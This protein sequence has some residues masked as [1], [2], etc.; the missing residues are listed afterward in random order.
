[1]GE[2]GAKKIDDVILALAD[3]DPLVVETAVTTLVKMGPAAQSA[4]PELERLKTR[5]TRKEEKEFYQNL[6][7]T[8][9]RMIRGVKSPATGGPAS[10][11]PEA[12]K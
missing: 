10:G 9:I 11:M 8:A 6:A 3:A 1:M 12:R 7:D 5:G 2:A 4:I